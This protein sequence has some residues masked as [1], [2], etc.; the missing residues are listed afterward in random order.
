MSI[1]CRK[2]CSSSVIIL[3]SDTFSAGDSDISTFFNLFAVASTWL[4]CTSFARSLRLLANVV[5]SEVVGKSCCEIGS[6]SETAAIEDKFQFLRTLLKQVFSN[7]KIPMPKVFQVTI[8]KSIHTSIFNILTDLIRLPK[9]T[10]KKHI[11]S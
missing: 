1:K 11:V 5:D 7:L 3:E 6:G 2:P 9:L 4:T 8:F 10:S